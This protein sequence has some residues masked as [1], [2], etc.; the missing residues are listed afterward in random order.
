MKVKILVVC[1][2][3][4]TFSFFD[5][6]V[7]GKSLLSADISFIEKSQPQSFYPNNAMET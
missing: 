1:A 3:F 7:A 2:R 6:A 5:I 4:F